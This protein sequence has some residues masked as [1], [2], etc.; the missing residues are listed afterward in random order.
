MD[1]LKRRV[2]ANQYKITDAKAYLKQ[3]M[4][5]GMIKDVKEVD[6]YQAASQ[7]KSYMGLIMYAHALE[8]M[9]ISF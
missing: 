4:I 9:R 3:D 8:T 7:I 6:P 2:T 5:E 1:K